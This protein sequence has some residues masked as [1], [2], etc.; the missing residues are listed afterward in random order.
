MLLILNL[1][2]R[3]NIIEYLKSFS[4]IILRYKVYKYCIYFFLI[5]CFFSFIIP[6]S[7]YA[8]GLAKE[9]KRMI[10]C[11]E[12]KRKRFKKVL[13]DADK[14]MERFYKKMRKKK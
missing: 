3:I 8:N 2:I 12:C 10:V 1:M 4:A 14:S 9:I 5:V 13:E 6:K 11:E 7:L